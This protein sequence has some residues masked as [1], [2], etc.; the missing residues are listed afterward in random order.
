MLPHVLHVRREMRTSRRRRDLEI[1]RAGPF[2]FNAA[3]LDSKVERGAQRAL[4]F[5][6]RLNWSL[7]GGRAP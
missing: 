2:P 1:L 7:A 4:D 6:A 5:V 3:F